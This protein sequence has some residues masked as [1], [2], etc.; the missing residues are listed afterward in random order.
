MES[1][2][3]TSYPV[4]GAGDFRQGAVP[5]AIL[6]GGVQIPDLSFIDNKGRDASHVT[7][8]SGA[9]KL[10]NNPSGRKSAARRQR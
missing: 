1:L 6:S 4:L 2:T 10:R 3:N 7:G 5:G 8:P 9:T